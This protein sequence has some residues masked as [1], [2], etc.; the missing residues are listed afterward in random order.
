LSRFPVVLRAVRL[1]RAACVGAAALAVT[2]ARAE[3]FFTYTGEPL[4]ETPQ[5]IRAETAGAVA[6]RLRVASYN[7]EHFTDAIGDGAERT[8]ERLARQAA[9]AARLVEEMN[10]DVLVIQEIE[11]GASLTALNQALKQPYPVAHITKFGVDGGDDQKMNLALLARVPVQ[12]ARE[13]DFAP[14]TGP[15][16][17]T[18]G[19]LRFTV[20]LGDGHRLVV[21][22]LHLKS[23]FGNR[24]RNIAQRVATLKILRADA[25]ALVEAQPE[26]K[27]EM[28]ALGDTNVDPESPQFAGD[29]SFRP[30]KGWIDVWRGRPPEERVTIPTRHGVPEMEFPPAT[31]DRFFVSPG[32][33]NAPW[34]AMPAVALPKGCDTSDATTRPGEDSHVSD[35]YPVYIDLAR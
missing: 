22:V 14:L 27:W 13:I 11:N 23:N 32:L 2:G 24:D 28:L 7:I 21:Y 3:T 8:A 26:V 20:D 29:A 12:D 10:P 33:T 25:D 15:G 18:R 35:H 31:F 34:S 17:P 9:G 30:L 4:I 1:A 16:R 19:L 6:E 5:V